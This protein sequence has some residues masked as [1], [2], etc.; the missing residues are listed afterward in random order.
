MSLFLAGG[1]LELDR[2]AL[3]VDERVDFGGKTASGA[4][5]TAISTPL[6]SGRSVLM[7][8][9]NRGVDHLHVAI[10]QL[11]DRV[12]QTIPETPAFRQRL[13]RL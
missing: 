7:D 13:K 10:V 12:H 2:A 4:T 8:A 3:A 1:E 6:F 9:D 11:G 5:Q